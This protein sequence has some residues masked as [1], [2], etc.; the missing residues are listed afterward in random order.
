MLVEPTRFQFFGNR[1]G[2]G[3][4]AAATSDNGHA[5]FLPNLLRLTL[6]AKGTRARIGKRAHV[7]LTST[8]RK[9]GIRVER[10]RSPQ[11]P[12]MALGSF[13]GNPYLYKHTQQTMGQATQDPKPH[14][15]LRP[16]LRKAGWPSPIHPPQ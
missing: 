11:A 1:I 5:L 2:I 3:H 4:G 12:P 14:P 15:L 6:V 10:H 13:A 8:L 7:S 9:N 16:S